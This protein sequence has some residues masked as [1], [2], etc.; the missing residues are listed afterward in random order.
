M[1][2]KPKR[3]RALIITIV[4]VIILLLVG[5]FLFKN[6]SNTASTSSGLINKIFSPLLPSDNS[7]KVTAQAGEDVKKGDRVYVA[8]SDSN[9]NSIVMKVDNSG[10][11]SGKVLGTATQNI[12]NGD[13]GQIIMDTNGGTGS[14]MSSFSDFLNQLFTNGNI[15]PIIP[16]GGDITPPDGG[17]ITPPNDTTFQ[18]SD[19]LD[20][21]TDSFI[22]ALDPNCHL[23]GDLT[24]DYVATHNDESSSPATLYQCN[25]TIDNDTDSFIDALDPNCHLDGDLEK[26]Y[27]PTHNSETESEITPEDNLPDLKAGTVKPTST[28]LNT[29]TTISSIITND[30]NASTGESF[31]TIFTIIKEGSESEKEQIL[32]NT[33]SK[34]SFKNFISRIFNKLSITSKVDAAIA[35]NQNVTPKP[36]PNPI[37]GLFTFTTTTPVLEAKTGNLATVSF[38]FNSIGIYS[39]RACADKSSQVDQG[40]IKES[41]EDNNCGPW[42]TLT[43]SGSLPPPGDLAQCNDTLDNDDDA[44]V[45]ALDPNCHLDGDLTKDYVATHNDES[46]SPTTLYQCNDTVDN[47]L[48]GKID[49]LDRN[50]HLDGDLTKDYVATHND[51]SS[52]PTTPI[53]PGEENKCLLIEQNPLI[54]TDAEKAR[55][56]ELLRK[57]YVIAPTLKTKDDIDMIY[58]EMENYKTYMATLTE[59]TQQCYLETGDR[60]DYVTFCKENPQIGC[61]PEKDNFST[62]YT[63][64]TTRYGNPWF[65]YDVRGSYITSEVTTTAS[66]CYDCGDS[67]DTHNIDT[68]C[69]AYQTYYSCDVYDPNGKALVSGCAWKKETNIKEYE[70]ILNIW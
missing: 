38:T 39:I 6:R 45:D 25:D 66:S 42:T 13:F 3:S 64:P 53:E 63:G 15:D 70:K 14:F 21:D 30:G 5:F 41:N 36:A 67:C 1:E 49:V 17:D 27:I 26:T 16:P 50:C 58:K 28:T 48:D 62:T 31:T 20:N 33:I 60:I 65:K 52:S 59:L 61:D 46:S 44:L 51:E 8:S 22:D 40:I 10:S 43:V 18:C 11:S 57:F 19:T 23:D 4:I 56:A 7:E 12:N 9:G 37:P 34:S 47:D 24:K 68:F 35:P 69:P 29:Q 32:D 2:N 54:F 55:L